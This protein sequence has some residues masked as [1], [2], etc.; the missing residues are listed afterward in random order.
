MS[1]KRPFSELSDKQQRRIG[2]REMR[3]E[4]EKGVQFSSSSSSSESEQPCKRRILS[5]DEECRMSD[6]E[7]LNVEYDQV[8]DQREN[9]QENEENS[10]SSS[11]SSSYLFSEDDE[12]DFL[13]DDSDDENNDQFIMNLRGFCLRKMPDSGTDE[14]LKLLRSNPYLTY[15]PRNHNELYQ[16]TEISIPQPAPIE[17]GH[18][19]HFGIR[20]NL[21]LIEVE[22]KNLNDLTLHF[23]WDGVRLFKSSATNIW[24]IVMHIEEIPELE[25]LLIGIFIGKVKPKNPNEFF[26]CLN[27]EIKDIQNSNFEVEV[28]EAGRKCVVHGG[29]FT[30]DVPA[31]LWALGIMSFLYKI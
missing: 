23:S 14:L 5:S 21:K 29:C 15:L 30:A 27:K 31:K 28:G 22:N 10:D 16:S 2:L 6:G 17:G 13:T 25:V 4:D 1:S 3:D 20:S 7:R 8:Q 24:P 19:L 18:Y 9:I 26:H 12:L 11:S